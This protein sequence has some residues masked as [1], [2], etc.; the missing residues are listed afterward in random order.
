MPKKRGRKRKVEKPVAKPEK[1]PTKKKNAKSN[2]AAAAAPEPQKRP[3]NVRIVTRTTPEGYIIK[4]PIYGDPEEIP[5]ETSPPSPQPEMPPP[6]PPTPPPPP[7]PP[8]KPAMPPSPPPQP[9]LL[10]PPTPPPQPRP[11]RRTIP[12]PPSRP[13]IF[14]YPPPRPNVNHFGTIPIRESYYFSPAQT[15]KREE[16]FY[17]NVIKDRIR[18]ELEDG[19]LADKNFKPE[20]SESVCRYI[21]HRCFLNLTQVLANGVRKMKMERRT[22]FTTQDFINGLKF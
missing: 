17:Q 2:E 19:A 22:K 13:I 12:P 8:P 16:D 7:P 9:V 4:F 6:P 18:S 5:E 21:S 1:A 15:S 14:S 10:L 3:A 11:P 20:L